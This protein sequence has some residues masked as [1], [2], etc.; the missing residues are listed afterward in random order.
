[1]LYHFILTG[2]IFCG[3]CWALS[4]TSALS[5]RFKIARKAQGPDV[6][7]APQT[8][9]DCGQ[10]KGAG[11]CDGGSAELANQFMHQYGI[12]DDTCAPYQSVDYSSY[13]EA[14]CED[15]M[16]RTCD[17][18]NTCKNTNNGTKYYVEEFGAVPTGVESMMAEIY[19]RG[20]IVCGIYAHSA[21]FENYHGGI[22]TD[23]TKYPGIT[24]DIS[25]VGWGQ[26]E[27]GLPYWIVRNSFGTI[28]GEEGWFLIER[29]INCLLIET[30]CHWS[31]PKI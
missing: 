22:I 8:L 28:W 15:S 31:T 27:A 13:T 26:T 3:S 17:F 1:M 4:T 29:G 10:Q 11:S 14:P 2:E 19:Q 9:L 21:S 16:C 7:L 18:Y 5:D 24:H 23:R 20:P 25:I 6:H 12:V 30:G